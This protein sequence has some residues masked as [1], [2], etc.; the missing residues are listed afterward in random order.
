MIFRFERGKHRIIL[1]VWTILFAAVPLLRSQTSRTLEWHSEQQPTSAPCT[2]E[3]IAFVNAPN[4]VSLEKSYSLQPS[5]PLWKCES[6]K[7]VAFNEARVLFV[8]RPSIID[9]GE[10]YALVQPHGSTN[11]DL[12]PLGGGLVPLK[13]EDDRHNRAAMNAIL[14][15]W[16][17]SRPDAIDWL[18]LCLAYLTMLDDAPSLADRYYSPSSTDDHFKPYTV[19]GF[20]RELPALTRKHLVPTLTCDRDY[21]CTVHFYYRTE[22]EMPLKVAD[23]VFHLEDGMLSLLQAR[24]QDYAPEGGKKQH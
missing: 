11:V 6:I 2:P 14:Q 20:L 21:Y 9:D 15:T 12:L 10:G 23:M 18:A 1:A 7:A 13:D 22:P 24:V 5:F 8:Y 17:K 19:R 3:D 16:N 4:Q